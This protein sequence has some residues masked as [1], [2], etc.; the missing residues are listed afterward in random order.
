[1]KTAKINL[2]RLNELSEEAKQNAI[3]EHQNFLNSI[4]I[5]CENED[6]KMVDEWY[7]HSEE[8]TIHSIEV[9]EYLF[10]ANGEIANVTHFCGNHTMAGQ[11][12]LEFAGEQ[13]PI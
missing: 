5:E 12:V 9:N 3:F 7:E 11:S 8:E 6:G 1:M 2:Y 4:P 13:Y 10:F